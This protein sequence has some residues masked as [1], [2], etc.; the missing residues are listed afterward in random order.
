MLDPAPHIN[1]APNPNDNFLD[2]QLRLDPTSTRKVVLKSLMDGSEVP[3]LDDGSTAI[4]GL[5]VVPLIGRSRILKNVRKRDH[6]GRALWVAVGAPLVIYD[7]TIGDNRT[8]P[9]FDEKVHGAQLAENMRAREANAE[10]GRVLMDMQRKKA[11][12]AGAVAADLAVAK[13]AN[14]LAANAAPKPKGGAA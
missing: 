14:M 13:L 10:H 1:H 11:A 12:E 4:E 6:L 3:F 2:R 5:G 8:V 7:E 9:A